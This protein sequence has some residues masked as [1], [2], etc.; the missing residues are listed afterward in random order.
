MKN[1]LLTGSGGFIGG[2]LK[3]YFEVTQ[4]MLGL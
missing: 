2:H 1:I 3:K 4:K